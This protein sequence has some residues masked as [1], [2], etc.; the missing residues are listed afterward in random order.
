MQKLFE[1]NLKFFYENL[2]KY[3]Q[4]I[5]SIK[6]RNFLI[7]ND[8][9]YF[10]NTPVYPN[11][12]STDSK[13]IATSPLTNP[14]WKKEFFIK[15]QKWDEKK[16]YKTGK[17]INSF[18][19]EKENYAF[20][21]DFLPTT[22]LFGLLSGAHLE[23]LQ[24]NY[25][26]QSL[27]I[28]EPNPEFFAISLYFVD[29]EKLY[30][31]LDKRLFLWIG[32]E[33]DYFAIEKFFYERIVTSS[34]LN[35]YYKAY[36]HPLI[37]DAIIKFSNIQASKLRGWGT[38]EDEMIGIN[39]HKKNINNF[40]L[41]SKKEKINAPFCVIAN[42]KS[43]EKSIDF[44]KKN[45]NSMILVSVGT[46]LKPLL[47]HN[48]TPDFHIEQERIEILPEVLKDTLPNFNGYFVGASVVR[49][50]VFNMAK[51]PLMFIREAFSLEECYP[52]LH[53]S[54]PI[55][56]NAGFAFAANYTD[57]IYLCGMDLGFKIGE[58][59]HA[60]GSFYDSR[61]DIAKDGIKIKGNFEEYVYTDSL[62]LSSKDKIEKMIKLLNLKVYNL[63]DGA[64]INGSIPLKD[65][66]LNSIDKNKITPK[67]LKTFSNKNFNECNVELNSLINALKKA[68]LLKVSNQKELTGMVDFIEDMIK[69]YA[70]IDKKAFTLIKGSL[71]HIL[72]N[73]YANSFSLNL[74]EIKKAQNTISE[75]LDIF[76]K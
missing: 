12:I 67:I 34:F 62:Y 75:N 36:N 64:Y 20:D 58:K 5:T 35:I 46:A 65:A 60:S 7:K 50:E 23:I 31:K 22:M 4:L 15:P 32:G 42:G 28:Y 56:G 55:V 61:D 76:S 24:N 10:N 57:T 16:F 43:L 18:I 37:D 25:Y 39:N 26:F 69:E 51:N 40:P 66:T 63:S 49:N 6:K 30:K 52:S 13:A 73:F 41:L 11:S 72:I 9:L 33:I 8:N 70:K 53:G 47:K 74:K 21:S 54:S 71:F 45:Q 68:F 38:Y 27:F 14:L 1:K 19:Q 59:K 48:I 2:P 3:Y 29:Y 17:I 44:I